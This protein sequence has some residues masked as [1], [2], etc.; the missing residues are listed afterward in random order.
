[1]ILLRDIG[2]TRAVGGIV[3]AVLVLFVAGC[4]LPSVQPYANATAELRDAVETTGEVTVAR[5]KG[6][7]EPFDPKNPP[8][9]T[10]PAYPAWELAQAWEVRLAAAGALVTYADALADITA[11]EEASADNMRDLAG[12][13]DEIAASLPG[14]AAPSQ[15]VVALATKLGEI[16]LEVKAAH[17]LAEAVERAQPAVEGIADILSQD[18]DDMLVLYQTAHRMHVKDT[19]LRSDTD[20][21]IKY[22]EF[23]TYYTELK[24]RVE[25]LRAE[26]QTAKFE[27]PS[28]RDL[29]AELK[30]AEDLLTGAEESDG[31]YYTELKSRVEALRDELRE[32]K[33]ENPSGRDLI[34]E[35]RE[36]E[37]L[38]AITE[39]QAGPY[40]EAYN[41]LA[42]ERQR[43]EA[44]FKHA[45][46]ATAAWIQTHRDLAAAIKA[47]R[48]PNWRELLKTTQELHV[49]IDAL[50]AD[51]RSIDRIDE[52]K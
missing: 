18:W 17:D 37:E 28:G 10:D 30:E 14:V 5:M 41:D 29:V 45:K 33:F 32:A 2:K 27:N 6:D 20:K 51:E 13:I 50:R 49:L 8:E 44:L 46:E 23:A 1:M 52:I 42:R 22:L 48:R 4:R 11:A 47:N 15:E 25:A 38:L 35:V 31:P 7:S 39:A 21:S 16:A 3:T 36:A 43:V 24:S 19:F 26:L 34:A 12:A 40:L 9:P